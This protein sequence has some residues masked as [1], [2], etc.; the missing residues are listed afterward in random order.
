M[1][2]DL[3]S[4]C[5]PRVLIRTTKWNIQ[6]VFQKLGWGEIKNISINNKGTYNQI[7]ID[8]SKWNTHD[9][10]INKI[11]QNLIQG[12]SINVVYDEPW[13]WKCSMSRY[14]KVTITDDDLL[15][16]KRL[17]QRLQRIKI[18]NH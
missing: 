1:T 6:K 3:P 15:Q 8:F 4:I 9:P 11:R 18:E 10:K 17:N 14:N 2:I 5:I 12:E 16:K 13:F 7:F